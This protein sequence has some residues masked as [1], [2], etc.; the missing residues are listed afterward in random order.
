MKKRI[1][2]LLLAAILVV[3]MVPAT[4]FASPEDDYVTV[5]MQTTS[6]T[7]MQPEPV[8][9]V[10]A[11]DVIKPIAGMTPV[12]TFTVGGDAL[13]AG[14]GY[15]Y[16]MTDNIQNYSGTFEKGKIYRFYGELALRDGYCWPEMGTWFKIP[17]IVNGEEANL[18]LLTEGDL[19]RIWKDF[20]CEPTPFAPEIYAHSVDKTVTVGDPVEIHVSAWGVDLHY[21]WYQSNGS[22]P[23]MVGEDSNSFTIESA[24]MAEHNDSTYFCVVSNDAG[25]ITSQF[26]H[27]TVVGKAGVAAPVITKQPQ[28]VDAAVGDTVTF[29]VT[30]T[31][32]GLHYQ[33]HQVDAGIPVTVGTDSSTY[34][35]ES[36]NINDHNCYDFY[37]VVT[38]DG[39][40]ATSEKAHLTVSEN[41]APKPRSFSDVPA[42]AWYAAD[43][44]KA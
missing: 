39:G 1:G 14:K 5:T 33:W 10:P 42:D 30:A 26:I 23:T 36:A 24:N 25:S 11:Y 4:A 20:V 34:T 21:Q 41:A 28:A 8:M 3:A 43:V 12:N 29:S 40:S 35:I 13:I 7:G 9:F 32:E 31:G 19:H 37:C 38:N 18:D 16:N 27:I 17:A 2:S 6:L 44:Q 22:F 15:W